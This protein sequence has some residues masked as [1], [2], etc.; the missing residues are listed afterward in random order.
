MIAREELL[1]MEEV[2]N[3]AELNGCIYF[4]MTCP[5]VSQNAI[6]IVTS[7]LYDY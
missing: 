5:S 4:I 7:V 2:P 6:F 1:K 3:V